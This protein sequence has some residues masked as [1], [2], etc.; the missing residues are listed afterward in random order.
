MKT[1]AEQKRNRQILMIVGPIAGL[2]FVYQLWN[3]FGDSGPTPRPVPVPAVAVATAKATSS[4]AATKVATTTAQLDP[5][6]HM[7]PMLVTESL[8]YTGSGRNIFSGAMEA[9]EVVIDKPVADARVVDQPIRKVEPLRPSG[10]PP[11]PPI[12][13]KFFGTAT[14]QNGTRRAF[15]LSGDDVFVASV[16]DVVQRRYKGASIAA[17]SILMED[18]PNS[19]KQTLPLVG[20]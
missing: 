12:N 15:L 2:L 8:V 11:L 1:G 16:G 3:L 10:P 9:P 19:N 20:N 14:S 18:M 6:L 17:N 5:T 4:G 7:G 13:L